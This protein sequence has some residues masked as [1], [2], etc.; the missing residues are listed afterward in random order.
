MK[1][2]IDKT[3]KPSNIVEEGIRNGL[4]DRLES[5][6]LHLVKND[7]GVTKQLNENQPMYM[8]TQ[9]IGYNPV[10]FFIEKNNKIH[11]LLEN[12]LLDFIPE[13]KMFKLTET[14]IDLNESESR[15]H[16]AINGLQYDAEKKIFSLCEAWDFDLIIDSEGKCKIKKLNES[17]D[18]YKDIP[19]D[20]I[21]SLLVESINLYESAPETNLNFRRNYFLKDADN[22][23]MLLENFDKL[24]NFDTIEVIRNL[25][26]SNKYVIFDT[27]YSNLVQVIL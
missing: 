19:S 20:K 5:N 21:K 4:Y 8:G 3:F 18:K 1:F 14:K 23:N 10:G 25:N 9:L 16:S 12:C 17:E 15:L 7:I 27:F 26:E 13:T 24:V 22:F 11:A 2:R 6:L